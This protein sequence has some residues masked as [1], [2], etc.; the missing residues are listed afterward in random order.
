MKFNGLMNRCE[1]TFD[2]VERDEDLLAAIAY[3]VHEVREPLHVLSQATPV[4]AGTNLSDTQTFALAT[5]NHQVSRIDRLMSGLCEF[6][7]V[8]PRGAEA[9][10]DLIDVWLSVTS[11]VQSAIDQKRQVLDWVLPAGRPK[12]QAAEDRI[13]QALANIV[14]NAS[15]YSPSGSHIRMSSRVCGLRV[16][17]TIKDEGCGIHHDALPHVFELFYRSDEA[18][19]CSQAGLG[20]GLAVTKKF[21]EA[22]GGTVRAYSDGPGLGSEFT[23]S[24]PLIVPEVESVTGYK[25]NGRAAAFE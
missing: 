21:I 14:L 23:V 18:R 17:I 9:T 4:L 5:V 7:D 24:L 3:V 6:M 13:A 25:S 2:V 12:V 1:P 11:R 16:D 10:A 22:S 19:T 15:K 20:L 8:G